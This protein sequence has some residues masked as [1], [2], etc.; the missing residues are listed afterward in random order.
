M[1]FRSVLW[2]SVTSISLSRRQNMFVQMVSLTTL[3]LL[4]MQ[5]ACS[6]RMITAV[7]LAITHRGH[8]QH[9]EARQAVYSP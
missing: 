3:C 2:M 5:T 4:T 9:S 7:S 8:N 1:S 6:F